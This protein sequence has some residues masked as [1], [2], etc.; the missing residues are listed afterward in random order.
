[1][2]VPSSDD[3][4]LEMLALQDEILTDLTA[5]G[6]T[7][8]E[9]EVKLVTQATFAADPDSGALGTPAAPVSLTLTPR[10]KV[11]LARQVRNRGG[12]PQE[13]GQAVMEVSRGACSRDALVHATWVDVAG[14]RYK[15]NQGELR[16]EPLIF[17][18]ILQR[19]QT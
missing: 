9:Y 4:R 17:K 14:D 13:V 2:G 3:F 15:I 7:M 11:D 18:V 16:E 5:D 1:M 10:P 12:V 8:R 6:L 19:E